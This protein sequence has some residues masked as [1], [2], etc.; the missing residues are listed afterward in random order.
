MLLV[1]VMWCKLRVMGLYV[2]R[3]GFEMLLGVVME[4]L[5]VV[6]FMFCMMVVVSEC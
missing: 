6:L 3:V 5:V 2:I 1:Y 4:F